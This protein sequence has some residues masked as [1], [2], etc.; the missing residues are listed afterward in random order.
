MMLG[1]RSCQILFDVETHRDEQ[2]ASYNYLNQRTN[3]DALSVTMDIDNEML[4]EIVCLLFSI[5]GVVQPAIV[6]Q[7]PTS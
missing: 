7:L 6:D 3:S 5:N 2:K 4:R 1:Y